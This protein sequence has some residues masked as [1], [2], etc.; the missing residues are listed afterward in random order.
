MRERVVLQ[1]I[2]FEFDLSGAPNAEDPLGL[3]SPTFSDQHVYSLFEQAL[4][5]DDKVAW[6]HFSDRLYNFSEI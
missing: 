2:S 1:T 5:V 6:R 3:A 4:A